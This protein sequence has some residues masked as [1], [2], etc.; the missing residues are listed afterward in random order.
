[1]TL[2][3]EWTTKDINE[4]K[5]LVA[6]YYP[7]AQIAQKLNRTVDA[8][9]WK[10]KNLRLTRKKLCPSSTMSAS[11]IPVPDSSKELMPDIKSMAK[12][13]RQNIFKFNP[14]PT[15]SK[16]LK[17]EK[18]G[19]MLSDMHTGMINEIYV[20]NKGRVITYNEQIR[21]KELLHLRNSIFQIHYLFQHAYN[22]RELNI[23]I[24][25]DMI[26]NDRIFEGQEFQID[27]PY[28]LQM[29]DTARD[30]VYFINEMKVK[31]EQINAYCV[32]GNHGRS[33]NNYQEEPVENNYEWTLYKII[34]KAFAG[35]S[36]VKIVVP[37]TRFYSIDICNHTYYMHHGDNLRG[38]GSRNALEKAAKDLLSTLIPD[39]PSGF[40]VYMCGHFHRSEKIDINEKST[41]LINGC[42]IPRDSY[43]F[44]VFRQYSKP[45]QWLFGINKNRPITWHFNLELNK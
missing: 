3:K 42:W 33:S 4:L 38:G 18:V 35:D 14:I 15:Y 1:M 36:R 23:M 29:W 19:L 26:T 8:V 10:L 17:E 44:K 22:M 43:G 16:K 12:I 30:L 24:L 34:E 28:G 27:R 6:N 45:V 41:V 9:C 37:N 39:L 20:P 7:N 32:V 21:Q 13:L 11:T 31:F 40:D 25:G 5:K 2:R